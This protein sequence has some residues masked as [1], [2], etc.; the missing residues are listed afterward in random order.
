L[1]FE[2]DITKP[3]NLKTNTQTMKRNLLIAVLLGGLT[4]STF[5]QGV[6]T[7]GAAS[8]KIKYTTDGSTLV[9]VPAAT[10]APVLTFGNLNIAI[11]S[12]STGTALATS[13]SSLLGNIPDFTQN[14]WALMTSA[15]IHNISPVAGAFGNTTLTLAASAGGPN[16]TEQLEIVGWTGSATSFTAALQS[17]TPI[18][19]GWGG[20]LLIPGGS[21]FSFS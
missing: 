4:A 14:G 17:A 8:G 2:K 6:V 3:N 12:A 7:L 13:G 19:I 1:I 18:M 10:P 11:Y 20:S 21:A 5:G 9:S 16:A 15:P